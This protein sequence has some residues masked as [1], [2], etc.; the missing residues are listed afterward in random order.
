M[1]DTLR[2]I[3]MPSTWINCSRSCLQTSSMRLLWNGDVTDSFIPTRGARQGDP[4]SPYFYVMC[5]E[6]LSHLILDAVEEQ[7]WKPIKL[8]SD[9]PPLSHLFFADDLILFAKASVGQL[10]VVMNCLDTFCK[11]SGQKVNHSKSKIFVSKNVDSLVISR[12]EEVAGISTTTH[13]GN[14]LGIPILQKRM[15]KEDFQPLLDKAHRRLAG[16]RG[17]L[18]SLARRIT[19]TK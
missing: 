19:L 14:Y 3:G 12:L 11:A 2:D 6:R 18:L 7:Q 9:C 13:L 4:L 1:E 16:W 15:S 17:K 5:M 8:T 10:R